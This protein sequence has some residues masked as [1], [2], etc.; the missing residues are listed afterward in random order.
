MLIA[1][2]VTDTESVTESFVCDGFGDTGEGPRFKVVF[3]G[4]CVTEHSGTGADEFGEAVTGD[5]G[6]SRRLV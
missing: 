6:E 1:I 5:I 3:R 4:C 2:D